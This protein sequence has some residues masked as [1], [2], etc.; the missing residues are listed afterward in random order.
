MSATG[1]ACLA[2]FGGVGDNLIVASALR[3]LKRLGYKVEMLSDHKHGVV[4]LNNPFID[5]L[6]I[7]PD[8][9]I[10][11]GPG[12][13]E[14]FRLRAK[15]YELFVHLSHTCEGR[16]AL[17]VGS[18]AFWWP[19][20][21]R[22]RI[23]AGSYLETVHDIVGVAHEFG[24][25]FFPTEEEIG[26]AVQTKQKLGF[27]RYLVWVVSGSRVDKLHPYSG[28]VVARI[29]REMDIPVVLMG[30]GGVQY[31]HAKTIIEH[32]RRQ[33]GS[34]KGLCSALTPEDND[35]GGHQHWDERRS[36]TFAQQAD[37]VVSPDTGIA[38]A[39]SMEAMP[40]V[41]MV[42]HAS[43]EN[44]TKHWSNT[45]SL[46]ADPAIIPCWPCHQLHDD[47]STCTPM[48]DLGQG[49]ACMGDISTELIVSAVKAALNP[50][51]REALR[52]KWPSHVTL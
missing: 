45:I 18:S 41:I 7:L 33:N 3:P 10:P 9:H 30:S 6:T 16:H 34:D 49:A 46:H 13:N 50:E 39:V 20:H 31:E 14:W 4:Y 15:E 2:R 40:K 5:K 22:R 42:S 29:I 44:I 52:A 21:Y 37:V 11:T 47:I 26:R 27:D 23:C 17:N 12:W 35:P 51:E 38:W 24:P 43:P 1:W 19:A 36:L 32:V 28:M 48:K 25:M 8:N